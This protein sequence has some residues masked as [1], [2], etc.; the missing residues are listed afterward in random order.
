MSTAI[1]S[2]PEA[3]IEWIV[4]AHGCAPERLRDPAALAALFDRVVAELSLK[5]ASPPLFHRFPPPG[6]ITGM[7]L[8]MESHLTCHTF[9][10]SG[11]CALNLYC[12]RPRPEWP[13][14]ERL[15]QALGASRVEARVLLRPQA[16]T[17]PLR[18][19]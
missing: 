5:P 17:G 6:G 12:C 1:A 4:D 7:L 13:W 9:P 14:S 3:G 19:A 11:L 15:A 16:L 2:A 8:L 10:E 18:E